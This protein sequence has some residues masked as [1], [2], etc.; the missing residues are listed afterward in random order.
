MEHFSAACALLAVLLAAAAPGARARVDSA[1]QQTVCVLPLTITAD[2]A[3]SVGGVI[4][5]PVEGKV[6][7]TN[8]VAFYGSVAAAFPGACPGAGSVRSALGGAFLSTPKS[9]SGVSIGEVRARA[10]SR[11]APQPGCGARRRRAVAPATWRP[12][13][14]CPAPAAH[15]QSARPPRAPCRPAPPRGLPP[16]LPLP[17]PPPSARRPLQATADVHLGGAVAASLTVENLKGM[18]TSRPGANGVANPIMTATSG[19]VSGARACAHAAGSVGSPPALQSLRTAV[20]ACGAQWQ[21]PGGVG[22]PPAA[23]HASSPV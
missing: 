14:G 6:V 20:N 3:A 12:T 2:S 7:P 4:M 17:K 9:V 1:A 18:L 22:A 19:A 10:P 15:G 23:T 21:E 16:P 13:R 11:P 5:R 8:K